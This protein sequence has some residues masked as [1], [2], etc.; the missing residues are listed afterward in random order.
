MN[1]SKLVF[2]GRFAPMAFCTLLLGTLFLGCSTD[3][4][5]A[6][7]GANRSGASSG[8]VGGR[9]STVT[10]GY[11]GGG[12]SSNATGGAFGAVSGHDERAGSS[13]QPHAG[14]GGLQDSS[15]TVTE[16]GRTGSE[17][18]GVSGSDQV[19]VAGRAQGGTD[20]QGNTS[21]GGN[22]DAGG[23][24]QAGSGGHADGGSNGVSAGSNGVS[25]GSN[26]VSAGQGGVAGAQGSV[27]GSA[28][29][30]PL[31]V[32]VWHWENPTPSGWA[33]Y[34]LWGNSATNVYA[35]GAYGNLLQWNGV[36]WREAVVGDQGDY[37]GVWGSSG[38][39]VFAVGA[40]TQQ[41]LHFDGEVW[42]AMTNPAA[43]PLNAIWGSSATNVY[44]VGGRYWSGTRSGV[45]VHYDGNEWTVLRNDFTVILTAAWGSGP[46]DVFI[47]G[48]NGTLLHFDG[49]N[50]TPIS[51]ATGVIT[52]IIGDG[53]DGDLLVFDN[54]GNWYRYARNGSTLTLSGQLPIVRSVWGTALTNLFAACGTSGIYHYNGSDWTTET[55]PAGNDAYDWRA[56]WGT[57]E[58][59]LFVGGYGAAGWDSA[60][61]MRRTQGQWI[62]DSRLVTPNEFRDVSAI[63]PTLAYAAGD[64]GTLARWD[65]KAWTLVDLGTT[66]SFNGVWAAAS[67]DV[68]VSSRSDTIYHWNGATWTPMAVPGA[69]DLRFLRG[70]SA[71]DLYV[72]GGAYNAPKFY[73]F[74]GQDWTSVA[75]P[76]TLANLNEF[77][78]D[79]ATSTVVVVGNTSANDTGVF[80]RAPTETDWTQLTTPLFAAVQ[81][82]HGTSLSD[83]Y[84][85][86]SDD[87]YHHN[88][89][90][91][92]H[93]YSNPTSGY[94][95]SLWARAI[96]DV[97]AVGYDSLI[98]H[99]DGSA[100]SVVQNRNSGW[101]LTAVHGSA[102]NDVIVV[103]ESGTILRFGPL[104]Q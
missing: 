28:G 69:T 102:Q 55:M 85:A 103:G 34:G 83:L 58:G 44:A 31:G 48:E 19:G 18:G 12:M 30:A 57:S 64:S 26:G 2:G 59:T 52:T 10:T 65:G 73:H 38:S 78:I 98:L 45:V 13:N 8:Y 74:N 104:G 29:S 80:R 39:D 91:W 24:G 40:S 42:A 41:I 36:A 23:G 46:S 100:W 93:A 71:H 86:T 43:L 56:V 11:A 81:T 68:F 6:N 20:A 96:G 92:A 75:L 5:R 3:E 54:G 1:K 87:I 15:S 9:A 61:L 22:A 67:N 72:A 21:T 63:S 17:S 89:T 32:P 27:A 76:A 84:V 66:T 33:V 95:T 94:F 35:V 90:I 51:G 77:W 4:G 60:G 79:P 47:G 82:V 99:F 50:Y 49:S 101:E 7:D 53:A 14:N 62:N 70:I 37:F 16:G 97:W 25:A 88:G